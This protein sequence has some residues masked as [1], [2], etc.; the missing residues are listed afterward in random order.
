MSYEPEGD[1]ID[2]GLGTALGGAVSAGDIGNL[3]AV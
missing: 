2:E 1:K 3:L